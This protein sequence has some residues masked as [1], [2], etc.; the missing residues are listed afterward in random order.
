MEGS[1]VNRLSAASVRKTGCGRP[2]EAPFG[3]L[4]LKSTRKFN[5]LLT[6]SLR[7]RTGNSLHG[8]KILSEFDRQDRHLA[9]C[10]YNTGH[11]LRISFD[12]DWRV[13]APGKL[14]W[15]PNQ[16]DEGLSPGGV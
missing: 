2:L 9:G 12:T 6:N 3:D 8:S 13:T 7:N 11:A 14:N 5:G 4:D 1:E 16:I 10:D 15:S